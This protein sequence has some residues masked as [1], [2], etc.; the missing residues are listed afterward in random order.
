MRADLRFNFAKQ[1][2]ANAAPALVPIHSDPVQVEGAF[3]QRALT[4]A[5]KPENFPMF[6]RRDK[7][8]PTVGIALFAELRPQFLDDV[9][10]ACLEQVYSTG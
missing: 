10:I 3:R 8:I 1:S 7:M 5:G 4:V 2:L 9:D 6:L